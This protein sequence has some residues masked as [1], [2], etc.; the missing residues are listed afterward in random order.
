MKVDK[1]TP[2]PNKTDDLLSEQSKIKSKAITQHK[3][4]RALHKDLAET[5]EKVKETKK[6]IQAIVEAPKEPRT[7]KKTDILKF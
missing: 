2:N 5:G 7:R 3:S 4:A 6:R 1:S